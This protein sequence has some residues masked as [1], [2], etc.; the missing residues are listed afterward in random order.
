MNR[1]EEQKERMEHLLEVQ[2]ALEELNELL[3]TIIHEIS[4]GSTHEK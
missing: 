4:I 2:K 3:D 1:S